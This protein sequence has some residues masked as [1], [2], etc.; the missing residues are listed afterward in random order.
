MQ[1]WQTALKTV[2]YLEEELRLYEGRTHG[3][4][5]KI[6]IKRLKTSYEEQIEI[7]HGKIREY[8][9]KIQEIRKTCTEEL[10][11]KSK[12]L[13]IETNK[14]VEAQNTIKKLELELQQFQERLLKS[15]E[16]QNLLQTSLANKNKQIDRIIHREEIAK[17]KV[18][19]AISV[20]ESALIEKDAAL[21]R[22]AQM[23][24]E[25]ARLSRLHF[26]FVQEN[27][28]ATKTK[29]NEIKTT[30]TAKTKLLEEELI[31]ATREIQLK[32]TEIDKYIFQLE[33]LQK[34][35]DFL[36]SGT[37]QNK[38]S[39]MNK[40]LVLEKNFETTFQ[41]LVYICIFIDFFFGN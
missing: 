18:K 4:V 40:L 23:R 32:N 9:Y 10:A 28:C 17:N 27:E 41:K 6:E 26:E 21:L 11:E 8:N 12:Q 7:L 34:Q 25:L 22:E 15:E 1:L 33:I 31:K 38:E 16:T 13:E 3:Y 19:E 24:E 39:D 5:P 30:C 37:S 36:H 2:D 14:S 20:V 29:I 35:V